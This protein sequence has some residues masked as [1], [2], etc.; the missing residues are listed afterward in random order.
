M[1]PMVL[2][3]AVFAAPSRKVE[4]N[5][6]I[7]FIGIRNRLISVLGIDFLRLALL[8]VVCSSFMVQYCIPRSRN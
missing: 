5:P 8:L 4:A 2:L 1:I 6:R 3:L 7:N